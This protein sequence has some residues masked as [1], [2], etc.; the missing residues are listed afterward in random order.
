M[1][2]SGGVRNWYLSSGVHSSPI[3]QSSSLKPPWALP[4][5]NCGRAVLWKRRSLRLTPLWQLTQDYPNQLLAVREPTGYPHNPAI[6]DWT[7]NILDPQKRE[8]VFT[9]LASNPYLN[10][11]F[12]AGTASA[13]LHYFRATDGSLRSS[14]LLG[15]T[16]GSDQTAMNLYCHRDSSRW[17][18]VAATWNFCVHDRPARSVRISRNGHVSCDAAGPICAVHGNAKSLRKLALRP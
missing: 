4:G 18:E 8:R 15:A 6:G 11:G 3:P 9:L 17:Q 10:G 14:D 16:D 13:L 7:R 1:L 12:G 2:R 5:P